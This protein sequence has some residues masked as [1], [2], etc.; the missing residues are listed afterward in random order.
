M[1]G[2]CDFRL[3]KEVEGVGGCSLEQKSWSYCI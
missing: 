2:Y 1:V 3:K